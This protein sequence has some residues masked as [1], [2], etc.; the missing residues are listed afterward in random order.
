MRRRDFNSAIAGA[1]AW[2]LEAHAQQSGLAVIG[3]LNGAS[4][5]QEPERAKAFRHRLSEAGYH[6]GAGRNASIEYGWAETHL[7]RLPALATELVR[8]EVTAMVAGYNLAVA[9]AA[10]AATAMIPIVF[11]AGVD[12]VEAGLVASLNRAD[13]NLA[14]LPNLSN[15]SSRS[16]KKSCANS[17]PQRRR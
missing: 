16:T 17:R 8:R 7:D 6:A 10:K 5:K 9:L 11:M 1:A 15:Q 4:E 13:G 3:Y 2:P 14:G 12:P